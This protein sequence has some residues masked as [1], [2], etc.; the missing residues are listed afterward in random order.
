M[1]A[2][3]TKHT[4]LVLSLFH[5][6]IRT[7]IE[8]LV[9]IVPHCIVLVNGR[10]VVVLRLPAL[11]LQ[12]IDLSRCQRVERTLSKTGRAVLLH[13]GQRETVQGG[14]ARALGSLEVGGDGLVLF[15]RFVHGV[16]RAAQLRHELGGA[17]DIHILLNV[18]FDL[19]L[20]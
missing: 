20:V 11:L 15:F 1:H 5:A 17:I 8:S 6:T 19:L 13:G 3:A 14:A 9:I 10:P 16:Q 2:K 7:V 18:R 12:S 4:E